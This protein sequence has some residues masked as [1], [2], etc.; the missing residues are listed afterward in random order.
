MW[1]VDIVNGEL[2]DLVDYVHKCLCALVSLVNCTLG[3]IWWICEYVK[4]CTWW[5]FV[6]LVHLGILNDEIYVGEMMKCELYVCDWVI[7][8]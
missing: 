5:C 1:L 3:D 8:R 4:M 6:I 7:L 2:C